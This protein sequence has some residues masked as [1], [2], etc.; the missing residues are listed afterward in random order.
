MPALSGT[1]RFGFVSLLQFG[2]L[3]GPRVALAEAKDSPPLL[4]RG[5]VT[6]EAAVAPG[7]VMLGP[8]LSDRT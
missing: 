4:P 1:S 2:L 7:Y 3:L 5:L 8:I 6:K